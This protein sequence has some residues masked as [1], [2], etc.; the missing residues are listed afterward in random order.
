ML[1]FKK[2]LN[3]IIMEILIHLQRRHFFWL[4]RL[5][6]ND[7]LCLGQSRF[8][9]KILL[10]ADFFFL[11][12]PKTMTKIPLLCPVGLPPKGLKSMKILVHPYKFHD[13][14]C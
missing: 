1:C 10:F 5:T 2:E 8:I 13:S 6:P 14:P 4:L 11:F 3:L 9:H 7:T 12:S